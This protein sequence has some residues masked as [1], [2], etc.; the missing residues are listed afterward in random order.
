MLSKFRLIHGRCRAFALLDTPDPEHC[1]PRDR[2]RVCKD[3]LPHF[4]RCQDELEMVE[5]HDRR[6]GEPVQDGGRIVLG[7]LA[8]PAA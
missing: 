3:E 5:G 7:R 1:V 4:D 2:V 8:P 6:V